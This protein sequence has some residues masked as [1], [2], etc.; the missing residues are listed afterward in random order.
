MFDRQRVTSVDWVSYPILTF[1]ETPAAVGNAV[2][3]ATACACA[4][5]H[6]GRS[7]SKPR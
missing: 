6:S 4:I 2:F 3:D 1:P 7:A 5:S